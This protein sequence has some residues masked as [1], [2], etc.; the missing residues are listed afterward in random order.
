MEYAFLA[1]FD[2]LRDTREDISTKPWV[3]PSGRA[4]M[5]LHF[6]MARAKEEILH[7]NIE[8]RRVAT[9]LK[10]EEHFLQESINL[11]LDSH[12]APAHQIDVYRNVRARYRAHHLQQLAV[13]TTL[14]GFSGT[15]VPGKSLKTCP[16]D[17]A[18]VIDICLPSILKPGMPTNPSGDANDFQ[19]EDDDDSEDEGDSGA[20][21]DILFIASDT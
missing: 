7:L 16:G 17:S 21:Q 15:I 11:A 1:D 14:P 9:F 18:G 3:T 19:A 4:A 8:V 2:L 6:K 12:P 20:L 10:D 5:D 13:M